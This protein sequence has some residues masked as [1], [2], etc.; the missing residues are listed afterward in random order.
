MDWLLNL[1]KTI[2]GYAQVSPVVAGALSIFISGGIG[3]ALYK[4]PRKIML[5]F[6][7]VLF[8]TFEINNAGFGKSQ[9][10]YINILRWFH[11]YE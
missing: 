9:V 4:A 11:Q 7:N 10:T 6:N 2:D 5:F 8:V 1:Y 3:F